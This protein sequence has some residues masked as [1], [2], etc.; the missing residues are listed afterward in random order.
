MTNPAATGNYTWSADLTSDTG[1]PTVSKSQTLEIPGITT[2]AGTG[3]TVDMGNNVVISYASVPT[4]GVTSIATSQTAPPGGTGQ[5]QVV[6]GGLYYDFTK[7]D[8]ASCPCIVTFPYDPATNPNPRL[9]HLNSGTGLWD[10]ATTSVDSVLHTVTGT[11]DSFSPFAVG[12]PNFNVSFG[13]KI[14]KLIAK[15]GNPFS[16]TGDQSLNI[17]FNLLNNLGASANPDGVSVQIWK[18]K[19]ASG[20]SIAPV[21]VST[22][23]PKSNKKGNYQVLLNLEK[24]RLGTGTYEIRVIVG[25]YG[26]QPG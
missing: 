13:K 8:S 4:A 6:S 19:D 9:Y 1:M 16:V 25:H 26:G 12:V 14:T 5:F 2:P 15:N 11:V 24:N 20:N 18:T 23:N 17:K 21:G 10:G 7:P 22:I 3:V